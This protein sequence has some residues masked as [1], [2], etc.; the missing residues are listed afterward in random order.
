MRSTLIPLGLLFV[1]FFLF[2]NLSRLAYCCTLVETDLSFGIVNTLLESEAAALGV[3]VKVY[4]AQAFPLLTPSNVALAHTFPVSQLMHFGEKQCDCSHALLEPRSFRCML[5]LDLN[6][7]PP[8]I[9][10]PDCRT[11]A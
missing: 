5:R 9:L 3:K 2:I 1:S 10:N 7:P 8:R 6:A 4:S 11:T